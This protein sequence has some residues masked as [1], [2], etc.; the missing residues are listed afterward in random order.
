[1]RDILRYHLRSTRGHLHAVP[2]S[3]SCF[4]RNFEPDVGIGSHCTKRADML[5]GSFHRADHGL[6][7]TTVIKGTLVSLKSLQIYCRWPK[8][9]TMTIPRDAGIQRITTDIQS[10]PVHSFIW[11]LFPGRM[12]WRGKLARRKSLG[13]VFLMTVRSQVLLSSAQKE[14]LV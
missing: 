4:P 11:C 14:S 1:M 3:L 9:T 12:A 10:L 8:L 2:E 7:E 6:A 13:A 5:A